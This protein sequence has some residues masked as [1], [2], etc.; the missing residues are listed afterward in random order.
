MT[1][2]ARNLLMNLDDRVDGFKFLI[3]DGDAKFTAAFDAVFTAV[4]ARIIKTPV[5]AGERLCRTLG[6]HSTGRGHR[7]DADRR[8]E[9]PSH[10]PGPV[11]R[12]VTT[13]IARTEPRTRDRQSLPR[14][15]RPSSPISLHRRYGV[16]GSSAG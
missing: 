6:A 7:P 14:S 1:Q 12:A 9:A 2:Q 3:R 15:L 11:R 5:R 16:A 4:G 10:G 8:A 13:S